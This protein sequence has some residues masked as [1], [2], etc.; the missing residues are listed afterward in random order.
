MTIMDGVVVLVVGLWCLLTYFMISGLGIENAKLKQ[1][2]SQLQD[3]LCKLELWADF[4]VHARKN[5][6]GDSIYSANSVVALEAGYVCKF[7]LHR[8]S[9]NDAGKYGVGLGDLL[10][11]YE[12]NEWVQVCGVDKAVDYAHVITVVPLNTAYRICIRSK[13]KMLYNPVMRVN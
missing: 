6:V 7:T 13:N 5:M 4:N 10:Y 12:D 2:Y 8:S 3:R 11:I 9:H 1:K